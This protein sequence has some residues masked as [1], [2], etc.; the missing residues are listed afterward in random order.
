MRT[1]S[2]EGNRFAIV[3]G[4]TSGIGRSLAFALAKEGWTVM[5][6]CRNLDLGR[7]VAAEINE[8]TEQGKAQV[9]PK[10]DFKSL[11]CIR[12]FANQ[13]GETRIDLLVNN[14]G[15]N[16]E[17][18]WF[19]EEGVPWPTQVNYVGH[20]LLTRL[21]LG[22][23]KAAESP[24]IIN[25]SSIMHR[26]A[27]LK[28]IDKFL[29][30]HHEGSY[31]NA[32]L[33]IVLFTQELQR[34]LGAGSHVK[35]YA[36][37]PGAV[38][39]SIFSKSSFS[40]F[41][42]NQILDLCYASPD[43]G[44]QAVLHACQSDRLNASGGGLFLARGLFASPLITKSWEKDFGGGVLGALGKSIHMGVAMIGS[45][46]D[47]PIRKITGSRCQSETSVVACSESANDVNFAKRLWEATAEVVGLPKDL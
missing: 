23:L 26:F 7:S 21:L 32:K 46:M 27:D 44:C 17:K 42:L 25:V 1:P 13:L 3:T 35:C 9:G 39:T 30:T 14:V 22:N 28:N 16:F 41:P 34:K 5:L 15:T 2:R 40:I 37:D 20:Y 19:S 12:Q 47:G 6:G 33:A 10:L 38:N 36:V 31:R 29:T 24:R 4:A 11:E 18:E 45:L 8:T 43:D